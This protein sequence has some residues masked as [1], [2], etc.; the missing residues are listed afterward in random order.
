MGDIKLRF[1]PDI[2]PKAV[3]NWK[4]HAKAGYYNGTIFHRVISEF[5]IQGGDP[6]GTGT[7][8]QS[9]WGAPFEME[10]D[11]RLHF[12]RGSLG[13][14]RSTSEVSQGS[15]FFI[16]QNSKLDE[17]SQGYVDGFRTRQNEVIGYDANGEAIPFAMYFPLKI[18]DTYTEIG[19][20]PSLDF[21]YT[22]FGHVIDGMD[23]VDAISKVETES[24][25]PLEDVTVL[26]I[27]FE[28]YAK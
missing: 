21:Q 28:P 20:Y 3:Q 19:G 1:F 12:I 22:V 23:I 5:M 2:A 26:S 14:A 8:G 18:I 7:G 16:V 6:L 11:P 27:T 15:Q 24:D 4:T 17:N 9:I 10:T 13:M 25:K